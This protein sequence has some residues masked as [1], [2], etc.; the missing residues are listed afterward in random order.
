MTKLLTT[1]SAAAF[2]FGVGVAP[3]AAEGM[4]NPANEGSGEQSAQLEGKAVYD[5]SGQQVGTV[6][7]VE[8]AADGT[9]QAILSVGGFLGIGEKKIAVSKSELQPNADGSGVTLS[10]TAEEIEAAP[11]HEDSAADADAEPESY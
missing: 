1:V 4:G 8:T 6:A 10:M 5:A 7:K 9:E 2:L 3:L 11:A